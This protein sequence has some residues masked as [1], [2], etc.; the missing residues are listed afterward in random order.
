MFMVVGIEKRDMASDEGNM[1]TDDPYNPERSRGVLTRNDRDWIINRPED[2]NESTERQKRQR[3]RDRLH[4]TILDFPIIL[5]YMDYEDV[6]R[7]F[8]SRDEIE[9][10]SVLH[11]SNGIGSTIAVL[12]LALIDE[13]PDQNTPEGWQ[14]ARLIESGIEDAIVRTGVS[15]E[16]VSVTIDIERG[17]RLK[18][19]TGNLADQ[20]RDTLLQMFRGGVITENELADALKARALQDG[21][22]EEGS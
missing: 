20:P 10:G 15:V 21:T 8:Q 12:Y 19:I 18:D 5:D 17:E 13:A 16:D 1:D 2:L 11:I 22:D 3:I 4:Q 9:L 14:F 6:K 7:A